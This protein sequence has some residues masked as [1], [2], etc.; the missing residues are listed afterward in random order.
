VPVDAAQ[1]AVTV[2]VRAL[3]EPTEPSN[4]GGV[5]MKLVL[6]ATIFALISMDANAYT[7]AF[8][9]EHRAKLAS[10]CF[11]GFDGCMRRGAARGWEQKRLPAA[12]HMACRMRGMQR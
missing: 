2:L 12:C 3:G 8:T 4:T 6:A 10:Y 5:P 1:I 9:K 11:D 7:F